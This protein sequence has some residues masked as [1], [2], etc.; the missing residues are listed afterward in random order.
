M[1]EQ[2]WGGMS[3]SSACANVRSLG[4][5]LPLEHGIQ[6]KCTVKRPYLVFKGKSLF[7]KTADAVEISNV[8]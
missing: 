6:F 8:F 4:V 7:P 1:S 3:V 5:V 2:G